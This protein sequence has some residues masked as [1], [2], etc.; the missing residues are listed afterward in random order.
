M[1][2]KIQTY[3]S[4]AV[5][6]YHN[7]AVEQ[8]LL[9][10]VEKGCCILYLWQNQRTV[11]IGSNQNAW[12]EC[13]VTAL[14]QDGGFLARRLSG[15]GAVFHDLGNLNFTFLVRE[16]DYDLERQLQVIGTA[17]RNLGI[18]VEKSG[19]NDLTVDGRKFSG[20]AFYHS[21]GYAYHHGTLLVQVNTEMMGKYLVPSKA[22]LESKGVKSVKSR[23][24][25]LREVAP[26]L[27]ID[28]LKKELLSAFSQVYCLEP[29]SL[30]ADAF[31]E[32]IIEQYFR[33][34]QSYEWKY[35]RKIPFTWERDKRFP[36]GEVQIQCEV[37]Q[38]IIED[39]LIYTDAV[40]CEF[41]A[42][43]ANVLQGCR[44]YRE[45]LEIRLARLK[46]EESMKRDILELLT[47]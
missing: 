10:H 9:E 43:A 7:L 19:R 27:T 6:P 5:N 41:P 13:R 45:D 32:E 42:A 26:G 12:K 46:M 8:Y 23:V 28:R 14:E 4:Q 31:D 16:E 39:I 38:G 33:R 1:I 37:N 34:N 40:D 25:N 24:I 44:F 2:T 3:I 36:W 17:C 35:G 20:N 29:E 47:E 21:N 11:V 18:Q 15:G 30:S 22:K